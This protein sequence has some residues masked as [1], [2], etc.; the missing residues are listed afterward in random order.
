MQQSDSPSRAGRIDDVV[1][2]AQ[3]LVKEPVREAVREALAEERQG[4]AGED[5]TVEVRQE[6]GSGSDKGG[7]NT[8][9]R[10]L[11]VVVGVAV[12]GYLVR[13]RDTVKQAVPGG[14]DTGGDRGGGPPAT[15]PGAVDV[16]GP[17][18]EEPTSGIDQSDAGQGA[19]VDEG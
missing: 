10:L 17:G 9:R 2:I 12:L 16:G 18:Y 13:N 15:E 1:T 4:A 6:S 19:T 11:G 8:G 3:G 14:G 5:G 7:S